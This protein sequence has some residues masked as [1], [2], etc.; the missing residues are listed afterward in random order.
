MKE[1]K[2]EFD[3][4]TIILSDENFNLAIRSLIEDAIKKGYLKTKVMNVISQTW[5]DMI[6]KQEKTKFEPTTEE[7]AFFEKVDKF[8]LEYGKV[9]VVRMYLKENNYD[10]QNREKYKEEYAKNVL[11]SLTKFTKSVFCTFCR[12]EK[13]TLANIKK[14]NMELWGF[15]YRGPLDLN[16]IKF[17]LGDLYV[18]D[19]KLVY[20]L[21]SEERKKYEN[22]YLYS[23]GRNEDFQS[24]IKKY[25]YRRSNLAE[26]AMKLIWLIS[27]QC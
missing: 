11:D 9:F 21:G 26:V 7:L 17:A 14:Y 22:I 20:A 5:S 3:P 24:F 12:E 19:Q 23:I 13:M 10:W 8:F 2:E 4:T 16:S 27:T 6:P 1:R 25:S 15:K 18:I